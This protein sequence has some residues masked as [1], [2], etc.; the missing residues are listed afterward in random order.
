MSPIGLSCAWDAISRSIDMWSVCQSGSSLRAEIDSISC[1]MR[2]PEGCVICLGKLRACYRQLE[3]AVGDIG[4]CPQ[5]MKGTKHEGLA[6]QSGN[7]R[8]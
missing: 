8:P 1:G 6:S 3:T 2:R 5:K 7:Q 4:I